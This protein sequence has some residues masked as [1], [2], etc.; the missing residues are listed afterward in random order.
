M[1][2]LLARLFIKN[3]KETD[4]P[5]VRKG[6]GT[7]T[8]AVGVITNVILSF[9][10]LFVGFV[11]GSAAI[12]ADALNNLTDVGTS[13]ITF[14]SFKV[15]AKPAD[16]GHPF[17][18]ARFEY[19]ASMAVSFLILL[20]GGELFI[21]SVKSLFGF[22]K[23]GITEITPFTIIILSV[24][25]LAKLWLF[26]FYSKIAKKINSSVVK[27][28]SADSL[29]DSILSLAVLG[30]LIVIYFMG[31]ELIDSIASMAVSVLILIAG[32]KILNETKNAL[33]GE[34][35]VGE[36][37]N[38]IM[39][40][41]AKYPQIIGI[42]DLLVH[43][44]GAKTYIASFHAEVNGKEDIYR[45]HDVIDNLEREIKDNFGILCTIHMDPVVFD[46][47][48]VLELKKFLTETLA[49][50]GIDYKIHDFRTVIGATHTKIIFDIVL[51]FDDK[52]SSNTL[53]EKIKDEVRK[54]RPQVFCVITVDRA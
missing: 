32:G 36:V 50:L 21:D 23:E 19:I 41:V 46:D 20:V 52:T 6:Y 45:L 49:D 17:G 34:A 30:S 26:L 43:N 8:S 9:I 39:N 29:S 54:R 42:H 28:A 1:T 11:S 13:V 24:S 5:A 35:P 16:K 40:T 2:E 47:E 14:I 7:L 31:F 48:A 51:P 15:S 27:A 12:I 3:Y 25:V 10:K 22:N 4:K 37:V 53:V 33:L 18:H 44:Y 38:N